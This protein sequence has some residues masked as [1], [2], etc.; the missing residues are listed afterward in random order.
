MTE[1][2]KELG[3]PA[4]AITEHGN[5]NSSFK[6]YKSCQSNGIKPILGYEGYLVDNR[7]KKCCLPGSSSS[8]TRLVYFL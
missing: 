5:L 8:S 3:Q 4:I 7:T 6:F 2:A 1:K